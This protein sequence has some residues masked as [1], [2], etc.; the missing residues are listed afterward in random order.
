MSILHKDQRE[1]G[2]HVL[3]DDGA[4]EFL[5]SYDEFKPLGA[6]T[7]SK[8]EDELIQH[9]DDKWMIINDLLSQDEGEDEGVD[10]FR[11]LPGSDR[12]IF[13]VYEWYWNRLVNRIL[14][15]VDNPDLTRYEVEGV[16]DMKEEDTFS[17]LDPFWDE[18]SQAADDVWA[19]EMW[20][21]IDSLDNYENQME[22]EREDS[23]FREWMDDDFD[24]PSK[25]FGFIVCEEPKVEYKESPLYTQSNCG[26][27]QGGGTTP[28]VAELGNQRRPRRDGCRHKRN[29]VRNIQSHHTDYDKYRLQA[30]AVRRFFDSFNR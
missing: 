12:P 28:R 13:D 4:T 10:P 11:W 27:V 25:G 24:S 8:N 1:R 15:F 14:K 5:H 9:I 30:V 2:I 7:L 21:F 23:L 29:G 19:A 17:Y 3:N 20:D 22:I 16:L 6:G 18:A 26:L